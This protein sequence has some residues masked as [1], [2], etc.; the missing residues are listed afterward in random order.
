[1]AYVTVPKDLT[2]VK[3]KVMFGLTKRQ[4]VCFGAAALIGVPLFFLLR[5]TVNSSTATVCMIVV[6]LPLFLLA[7]YEKDGQP[8]EVILG[9]IIQTV[10]I[11][12]KE[13]PYMTNNFYAAVE[14]QNQ[15]EKEVRAIVRKAKARAAGG[16]GSR[17]GQADRR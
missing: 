6:M 13:R 14:R 7:M 5:N 2:K 8:L 15:V 1:M 9:Q 11:R 4:L 3:S 16:T 10:F 12:P 17:E